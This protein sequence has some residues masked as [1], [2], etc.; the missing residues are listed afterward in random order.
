M[1]NSTALCATVRIIAALSGVLCLNAQTPSAPSE[2]QGLPA[3]ATPNDYQV[4]THVGKVTIAAEFTG[5]AIPNAQEALT[6]EEYVAVEVGI[7][8][9]AGERLTIAA[10]E[11]SLR[12][13][14][15]K[16]PLP[17]QPWGLV[18]KSIKDPEWTPPETPE[19]EKPKSAVGSALRG[20]QP[21]DDVPPRP[22]KP[23]IELIRNWQ[24]R[25][26]KAALNEGDRVL[27]QAGLIFF[28][29]TG[30]AEKIKSID[31]IYE[32]PAGKATLKLQ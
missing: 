16:S 17:S 19:A 7:F 9:P 15:S 23:P 11:F 24:Q 26:K 5:H 20:G 6:S 8:G 31:L 32:G 1:R 22:V 12:I 27:P 28:P 30:K 18:A 29:F 10:S 13:N 25:L 2:V 21:S 4:Q 14:G 3:R